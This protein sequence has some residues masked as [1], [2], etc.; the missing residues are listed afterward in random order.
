MRLSKKV[1]SRFTL[2]FQSLTIALNSAAPIS[3]CDSAEVAVLPVPRKDLCSIPEDTETRHREFFARSPMNQSLSMTSA[4]VSTCSMAATEPLASITESTCSTVGI[5]SLSESPEGMFESTTK[6]RRS[7]GRDVILLL[8][9]GRRR[10]R[11][12]TGRFARSSCSSR[13][14]RVRTNHM[15]NRNYPFD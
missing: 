5:G 1:R 11:S 14:H 15:V 3:A 12:R 10:S 8:A 13:Q 9:S 4:T 6:G 2:F 7:T